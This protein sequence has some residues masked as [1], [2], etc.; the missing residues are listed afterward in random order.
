MHAGKLLL[1]HGKGVSQEGIS[2]TSYCILLERLWD[3][4][5]CRLRP[6]LLLGLLPQCS[7]GE[8]LRGYSTCVE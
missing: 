5:L 3:P 1:H 8:R 7:A 4:C 2:V 6:N